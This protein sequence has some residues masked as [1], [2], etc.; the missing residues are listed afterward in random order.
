MEVQ[1]T[2]EVLHD[3]SPRIKVYKNGTVERLHQD[4]VV[5]PSYDPK[6]RVHSKDVTTPLGISARIYMPDNVSEMPKLPLLIYIHGGAF[7]LYSSSSSIYHNYL[8][9]L[10]SEGRIIA[11]SPNYRLAPEFPIPVCYDDSWAVARWVAAHADGNGPDPW[12]NQFVDFNNVYLGGDSAGANIAHEMVVRA[13][14]REGLEP[15]ARVA[16]LA[17]VHPFFG[18]DGANPLWEFLCP[19]TDVERDVRLD[20]GLDPGRLRRELQ[21]GRVLVCV[22]EKDFLKRK[23]VRYYELLKEG[24]D[25]KGEITMWETPGRGHVF[26]LYKPE[27][28]E[29]KELLKCIATFIG[30]PSLQL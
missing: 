15:K 1:R 8:N 18:E 24:S 20:P 26:H 9:S 10:V 4:D 17:L 13:G 23:A 3:F 14:L 7:C 22:G 27:C 12:L 25:W 16:G 6:R 5:P 11:V 30:K 21:C 2:S 19:T 29:A 28:D